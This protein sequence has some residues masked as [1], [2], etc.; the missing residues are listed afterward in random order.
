MSD[1]IRSGNPK[2]TDAKGSSAAE[3]E[4]E[5]VEATRRLGQDIFSSRDFERSSSERPEADMPEMEILP[6]L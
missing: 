1:D 3:E 4:E 6:L 5:E 2:A